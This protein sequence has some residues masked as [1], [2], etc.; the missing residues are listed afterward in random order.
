MKKAIIEQARDVSIVKILDSRGIK[1]VRQSGNDYYYLSPLRVGDTDP[2]FHVNTLK[3]RWYDFGLGKGRDSIELIILLDGVVF[4]F[5]VKSLIEFDGGERNFLFEERENFSAYEKRKKVLALPKTEIF[6][7]KP[8]KH[9]ALK[10][11]L[12]KRCI[13]LDLANV[14]L[15]EV[16]FYL[17]KNERKYFTLGFPSGDGFLTRNEK[18][19]GFVGKNK[20]ISF[21]PGE[22]SLDKKPNDKVIIFEGF[23]DF[24]SALVLGNKERFLEDVIILHSV[25]MVSNAKKKI[26]EKNYKKVLLC[27][28]NDKA[29]KQAAI[30]FGTLKELEVIDSSSKYFA[31]KDLNDYLMKKK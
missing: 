31:F 24:L 18:M 7:I 15:K 1:P 23:F 29:G 25:A 4:P 26:E 13:P 5:A 3:N 11:Y 12:S 27:L 28:D 9:E 14:Y 2:S 16:H 6:H 20:A 19:P 17:K 22:L 10:K 30:G 21:V 8:I